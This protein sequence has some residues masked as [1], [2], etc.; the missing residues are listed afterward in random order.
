MEANQSVLVLKGYIV[1]YQF[2]IIP[3][4]PT[5]LMPMIDLSVDQN[6]YMVSLA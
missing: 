4:W 6:D 5:Y 1:S 3:V 2:I